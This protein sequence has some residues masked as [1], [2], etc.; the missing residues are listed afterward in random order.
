MYVLLMKRDASVIEYY[1]LKKWTRR[2][3]RQ[4]DAELETLLS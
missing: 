1:V 2:I 3:R 4:G